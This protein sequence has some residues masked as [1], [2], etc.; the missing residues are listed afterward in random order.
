MPGWAAYRAGKLLQSGTLGIGGGTIQERLNALYKLLEQT[1]PDVVVIECIRGAR[2]HHH[3]H[4]SVGV[5]VAA[6]NPMLVLECP[7]PVWK[8]HVGKNHVKSDEADALA[9][10]DVTMAIARTA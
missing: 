5:S 1:A 3:L 2:V 7:V 10:G 8:K 9:I 6:T 4:W